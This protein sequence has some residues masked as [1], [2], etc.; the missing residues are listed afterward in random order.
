MLK[1]P[2]K[3][4]GKNVLRFEDDRLLSGNAE[5]TSDIKFNNL[6]HLTFLRSNISHGKII[7][8]NTKNAKKLEGVHGVFTYKDFENIPPIKPNSRM[9]GYH[10]TSQYI[11]CN[12]KVRYVGEPIAVILAENRYIGEDAAEQI[13]VDIEDLDP[14]IDTLKASEPSSAIVHHEINSNI[15]LERNF[16]NGNGD[17]LNS[18]NI[19]SVK[20]LFKMKRKSPVS[21]EPRSYVCNFDKRSQILTLFSSTQVPG[22]IKDAL[23]LFLKIPG[24]SL[25]VV[26]PDV[27]GGFGGKASLYPE[28]IITVLLC[29]KFKRPIKW[30]SDR[31]EDLMSTSQGFEEIMD[32]EL[33]FSKSGYFKGLKGNIIGDVGAYSIYPWT[34]ALEPMQVAGF[35]QGPYKI[36]NF[37]ANVKCVVTNKP[38][39]GPYRG[40]GRP[41]AVFAIER[42]IDMA[43][44]KLKIDPAKLRLLNMIDKKDL[45]FKIGSGIVWDKAGFKECLKS[46]LKLIDYKELRKSQKKNSVNWLGIGIASYG[47]LTGIGSKI[48]VAPGMPLNTGHESSTIELDSTGSISANFAIAS[49]GQGLETTLAQI[50]ADVIGTRPEEIK[51]NQGNT[52]LIKHGT[53]TYASRSAAIAG[54]VAIKTGKKLKNQIV[55]IA[56]Y[57][58]NTSKSNIEI[59]DG[60]I[61][62]KQTNKKISFSELARAVYSDMELL[63]INLRKP[64]I[65]TETYDPIF[66]AT[67]TATHIALVEINSDTYKTT[68]KNYIVS[69]DCGKVINPMIVDGQVHGG[70]AQGIGAALL[71]ELKYD[72]NGQL[73]TATLADYLIPTPKEVPN[74]KIE[75]IENFLPN[76]LGKFKGMGE[77]GTIGATAAIANAVSD[78]V[79]HLN[80]EV[81]ELPI[82]PDK[83][84]NLIKGI[85][86]DEI[87]Y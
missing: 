81:T 17:F 40:V 58:F 61:N 74:I 48:S 18:Q 7:S 21:M 50:I 77:G 65:F 33:F 5:Y 69:E 38:P 78:A 59:K 24:N 25:N 82:S 28:E 10:A 6:L 15:I 62:Q 27:G 76:N 20:N 9:K 32:V 31:F 54:S 12:D 51:I 1:K 41:A 80:V 83:L 34:A 8:I 22:V 37:K 42:L 73:Q 53:G 19:L 43:A 47:E 85:S 23:S 86:E 79:S 55:K 49:H 30:V 52:S 4:I 11:L 70:I 13:E 75:H 3:F 46:A 26:A 56:S 36:E 45:P 29:Q 16:S 71:E 72:E 63:P 60:F 67:T 14:V 66:G 87:K 84:Y 68:I 64:L 44:K 2:S 39:T 35:L 57:L